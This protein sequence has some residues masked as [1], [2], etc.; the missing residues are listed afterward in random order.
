M[1]KRKERKWRKRGKGK[2]WT[3][4]RKGENRREKVE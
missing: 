1:R 4:R 2:R 3:D